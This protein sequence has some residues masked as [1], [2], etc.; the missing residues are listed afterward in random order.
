LFI[1]CLSNGCATFGRR[2]YFGGF[3]Y[4]I[5]Q[6]YTGDLSKSLSNYAECHAGTTGHSASSN[7]GRI[8][9]GG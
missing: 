7:H 3:G 5:A 4:V 1:C 6:R 2:I 8:R 9:F